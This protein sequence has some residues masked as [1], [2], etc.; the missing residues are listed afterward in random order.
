VISL[1]LL[2]NFNF[3]KIIFSVFHVSSDRERCLTS[4]PRFY[5]V[6]CTVRKVIFL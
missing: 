5:P 3:D 1:I 6:W 2:V 4:F